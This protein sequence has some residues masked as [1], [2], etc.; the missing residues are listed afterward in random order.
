MK[1]VRYDFEI[2][3]CILNKIHILNKAF[4]CYHFGGDFQVQWNVDVAV[5]HCEPSAP[6]GQPTDVGDF[7]IPWEG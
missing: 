5:V 4:L 7:Q 2:I 3:L 6:D 1:N